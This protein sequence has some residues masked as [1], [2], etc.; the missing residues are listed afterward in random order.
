[1]KMSILAAPL[2]GVKADLMEDDADQR[3]SRKVIGDHNHSRLLS[4]S[5]LNM[6]DPRLYSTLPYYHRDHAP[7]EG[8]RGRD[9]AAGVRV[10]VR[11][12]YALA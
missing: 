3:L 8:D 9:R 7:W 4:P 12:T 2:E 6:Q 10:R 11:A 5:Q 1:M